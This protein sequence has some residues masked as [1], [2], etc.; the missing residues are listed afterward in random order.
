MNL[1]T[2]MRAFAV[3]DNWSI[4]DERV[5]NTRIW[6][7][8]RLEFVQVDVQCSI[9][10]QTGGDRA[11]DLGNQ[12]IEMLIARTRDVEITTA[13]I[14]HGFIIDQERT[15]GVLNRAV[16]GENCIVRLDNGSGH[17]WGRIDS[18]FELRL[19]AVVGRQSFQ[20]KCS[21]SRSC[22]TAKRMED[23]ESLKGGA[24][25]CIHIRLR[26]INHDSRA[27]YQQHGECGQ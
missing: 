26:L 8:V 21:K 10:A 22:T 4:A 5:V 2:L 25:V 19:L 1:E 23:Q 15:V 17:A 24:I 11:D 27:Q 7:Q 18:E 14:V 16:G 12:T 13:D 6:H 20:E 3:P 9:K